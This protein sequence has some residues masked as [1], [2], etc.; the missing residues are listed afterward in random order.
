VPLNAPPRLYPPPPAPRPFA[1]NYAWKLILSDGWAIASLVSL[2]IGG[3]FILVGGALMLGIVTAFVGIPFLLLAPASLIMG[4]FIFNQRLQKARTT[5]R[6]LREGQH[7]LGQIA[8]VDVNYAV[9]VNGRHPWTI[10]YT[11]QLNGNSYE[12]Q[13]TTL[14]EPHPS[15]KRGADVY[16]LYLAESPADN[17]LYP[18]P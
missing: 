8:S 2:F 9:R 18:H 15:I 16:I 4:G 1:D 5:V 17:A 6:V 12:G 7:V 14:N 13:V 10:Q 11:F 3:M